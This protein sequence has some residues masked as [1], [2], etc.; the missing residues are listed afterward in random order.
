MPAVGVTSA[1]NVLVAGGGLKVGQVV[2]ASNGKGEV[3]I[4]SRYRPENVLAMVYRHL[5]IDSEATITDLS[6]RP[7]FLL[8]QRGFIRELV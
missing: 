4:E 7:R 2:G 8:E 1:C 3:P 6:G 5:G